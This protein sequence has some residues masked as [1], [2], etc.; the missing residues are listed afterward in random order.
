MPA[1]T[2][3]GIAN[4]GIVVPKK[5]YNFVYSMW[6]GRTDGSSDVSV[7]S[8]KQLLAYLECYT[9]EYQGH[10]VIQRPN[11]WSNCAFECISVP[12]YVGQ[13]DFE[14]GEQINVAVQ[15]S[16]GEGSRVFDKAPHPNQPGRSDITPTRRYYLFEVERCVSILIYPCTPTS[17]NVDLQDIR[18][19]K[20]VGGAIIEDTDLVDGVAINEIVVTSVGGPTR[21]DKAKIGITNSNGARPNLL[22]DNTVVINDCH[23]RDKVIKEDWQYLRN[24]CKTNYNVLIQ[25]FDPQ[26]RRRRHLPHV[27]KRLNILAIKDVKRDEIVFLSKSSGARPDAA[28]TAALAA[29]T[30]D[31]PRRTESSNPWSQRIRWW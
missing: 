5:L 13:V 21:I 10:L 18:T 7:D 26:R 31:A 30:A 8:F 22:M 24:M 6:R 25:K 11:G 3:N 1:T 20:K 4:N 2:T 23:Q 15:I 9:I 17:S 14:F 19:V 12:V 27:L 29:S 16:V 28:H